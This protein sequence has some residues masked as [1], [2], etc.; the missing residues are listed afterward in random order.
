MTLEKTNMNYN[1]KIFSKTIQSKKIY[2][3]IFVKP[4]QR[5]QRCL[6]LSMEKSPYKNDS[7]KISEPHRWKII[8][9]HEIS[10]WVNFVKTESSVNNHIYC[11]KYARILA[12]SDPYI[13]I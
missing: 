2:I 1:Y 10:W 5:Y 9:F 13:P 12:F 6:I 4:T 8:T 3:C 11:V 7:Y